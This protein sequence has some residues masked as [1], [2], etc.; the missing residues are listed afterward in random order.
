MPG[1]SACGARRFKCAVLISDVEELSGKRDITLALA[2]RLRSVP[3]ALTFYPV[4][5][6]K[7]AVDEV[8]V[9]PVEFSAHILGRYFRRSHIA[10]DD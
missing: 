6:R 4:H 9:H 8:R 7:A 1:A 10:T 2:V 3:W 5:V